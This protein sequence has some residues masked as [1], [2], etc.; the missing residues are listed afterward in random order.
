MVANRKIKK[1]SRTLKENFG[2]ELRN[3]TE[4][5]ISVEANMPICGGRGKKM[6]EPT[7]VG[8]ITLGAREEIFSH[9]RMPKGCGNNFVLGEIHTHVAETRVGETEERS[10]KFSIK[11]LFGAH[12]DRHDFIC[13]IRK[14]KMVC[15][16][17]TDINE[18]EYKQTEK[19]KKLA[20]DLY[21]TWSEG[22]SYDRRNEELPMSWFKKVDSIIKRVPQQKTYL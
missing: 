4:L 11:D 8:D 18:P 9:K 20:N 16:D 7:S 1:L 10:S 22:E 13:V 14:R 3:L 2:K 12:K 6:L 5:G 19:T 15:A 21:E 17:L